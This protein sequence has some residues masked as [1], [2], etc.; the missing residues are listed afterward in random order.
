[1]KKLFGKSKPP[2]YSEVNTWGQQVINKND[3]ENQLRIQ[4]M[5]RKN[6]NYYSKFF[7]V[8]RKEP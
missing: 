3:A 7:D 1:M 8:P 6:N 2:I 5:F 4:E